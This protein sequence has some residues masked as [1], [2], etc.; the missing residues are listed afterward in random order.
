MTMKP[1]TRKDLE[2]QRHAYATAK[3]RTFVKESVETIY[4][5]AI[6][7]AVQR[8]CR[9]F[10]HTIS[11]VLDDKY[12]NI[13]ELV[14]LI[15]ACDYIVTTSNV[16]AHIAGGL[17]KNVY[18]LVPFASGKLWYWHENDD[19]SIWYPSVKIFRQNKDGS[20][21]NAITSVAKELKGIVNE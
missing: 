17:G 11:N 12:N 21:N 7:T 13:D 20:W 5:E 16:T 10:Y 1:Y 15:D 3:A 19:Q 2:F 8:S 14:S 4:F 9:E 6:Q 18:L